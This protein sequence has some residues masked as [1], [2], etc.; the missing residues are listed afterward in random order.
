LLDQ[1]QKNN[2]TNCYPRDDPFKTS[3]RKRESRTTPFQPHQAPSIL[4]TKGIISSDTERCR[5]Y[6]E[7]QVARRKAI[8]AL[9]DWERARREKTQANAKRLAE[10]NAK[11]AKQRKQL[12]TAGKKARP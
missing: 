7:T 5:L 6:A 1:R 8:G 9:S 11:G 3:R 12:K 4:A 2:E 10:R